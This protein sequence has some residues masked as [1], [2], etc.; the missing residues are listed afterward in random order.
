M[1]KPRGWSDYLCFKFYFFFVFLFFFFC[2]LGKG[3]LELS[4]LRS[5]LQ[6]L[7]QRKVLKRKKRKVYKMT[8]SLSC[9]VT[10]QKTVSA[11]KKIKQVRA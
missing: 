2:F 4:V 11:K 7:D 3:R 8:I 5:Y 1:N 10:L 9:L 6:R